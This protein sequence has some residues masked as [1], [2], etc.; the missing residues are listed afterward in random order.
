MLPFRSIL[1]P[2]DFSEHS[3]HALRYAAAL[4]GMARATL[5]VAWVTDPLL[6]RAAAVYALDPRGEQTHA[7]LREFVSGALP[8]GV[9]WLPEPHLVISVGPP[10]REI[11]KI[12]RKQHAD[13]IVVGTHGL[14]G[15][16][17][18]FFGSTTERVL[19]HTTIPVLAVPI[20]DGALAL[21]SEAPHLQVG[22]IV[23]AIDLSEESRALAGFGA[24]LATALS[25]HPLF[26]HVVPSD[27]GPARWRSAVEAHHRSM[28]DDAQRELSRL[29]A[30]TGE[31]TAETVVL[32][33]HPAEQIAALAATRH[34]GLI[35]MG[36]M[37][38]TGRLAPRPGS[39]AYRVLIVTPTP[40]LAVPPSFLRAH[41]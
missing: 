9:P 16:R 3:A 30:E 6:D 10:D 13:L 40:V 27:S 15:Y 37:S 25:A 24:R 38:W 5:T 29:A 4:A 22:P 39:I 18:M 28:L 19:R 23:V 31:G 1:C 7:D 21:S 17:K 36:L 26:A 11:L 2:V 14:S 32:P 12:A 8:R 34:A 35:V 20:P 33:G 41:V